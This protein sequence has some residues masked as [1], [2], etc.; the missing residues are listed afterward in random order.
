MKAPMSERPWLLADARPTDM[1]FVFDSWLKSYADSSFACDI[2][3][4]SY[5]ANQ[6]SVIVDLVKRSNVV[7]AVDQEDSDHLFG[8]ACVEQS[9]P[10]HIV[11]Y[12]FVKH[13]MRGM[14][15]ARSILEAL[16]PTH[17]KEHP[18]FASHRPRDRRSNGEQ[19]HKSFKAYLRDELNVLYNPYLALRRD[20]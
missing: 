6:Q 8:W 2:D 19:K 18:L 5:Y 16:V 17:S 14:G 11:H 20:T 1:A 10:T 4:D 3:N 7:V 13:A 15:V 9:G 12:V